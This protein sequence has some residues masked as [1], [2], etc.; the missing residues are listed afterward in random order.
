MFPMILM[1]AVMP[2][3]VTEVEEPSIASSETGSSRNT[4]TTRMRT[5]SV[6]FEKGGI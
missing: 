5:K 1:Q 4:V 2:V 3:L 6:K